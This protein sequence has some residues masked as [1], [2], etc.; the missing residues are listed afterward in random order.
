[1][2]RLRGRST[3]VNPTPLC[4]PSRTD[5]TIDDLIPGLRRHRLPSSS[6]QLPL[7]HNDCPCPCGTLMRNPLCVSSRL[8]GLSGNTEKDRLPSQNRLGTEMLKVPATDREYADWVI[9]HPGGFVLNTR[10]SNDP[11]YMVLHAASCRTISPARY[12]IARGAL[13]EMEYKKV[14]VEQVD[15]LQR[16][17]R[18]HGRPD[19][20]FSK[21][22]QICGAD[23]RR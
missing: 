2:Q 3:R 15:E 10:R 7:G 8:G 11:S 4:Q 1:M 17:V 18:G 6:H 23:E 20:S 16:W 5:I 19:G 21:R 12:G 14:C 22:C 13:T 9:A